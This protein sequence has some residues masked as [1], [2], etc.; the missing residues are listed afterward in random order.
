MVGHQGAV[1]I[2]AAGHVATGIVAPALISARA[3][4]ACQ[5][6]NLVILVRGLTSIRIHQAHHVTVGI[7]VLL[8]G[9]AFGGG[10]GD[11]T[12]NVV[13]AVFGGVAQRIRTAQYAV[14]RVVLRRYCAVTTIRLA[15]LTVVTIIT[16]AADHFAVFG[17]L[18]LATERIVLVV[19]REVQAIHIADFLRTVAYLVVA[20]A[21][22]GRARCVFLRGFFQHSNFRNQ[23]TQN[24]VV[25][26]N[27]VTFTIGTL[28]LITTSIVFYGF[29]SVFAVGFYV[30]Q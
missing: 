26:V 25:I 23:L 28:R 20:P 14:I 27:A 11:A 17:D 24:I 13:V 22:F 15:G 16:T 21:G 10:H 6:T 19:S 5:V 9:H 2:C 8:G 12:G 4:L 29:N 18:S 7:T 3:T 1:D 30:V